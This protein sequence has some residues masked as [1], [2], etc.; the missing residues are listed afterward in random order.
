VQEHH[1]E[2]DKVFLPR[3]RAWKR[4]PGNHLLLGVGTRPTGRTVPGNNSRAVA[5]R[6]HGLKRFPALHLSWPP[7]RAPDPLL[8]Q[9]GGRDQDQ[10]QDHRESFEATWRWRL[11]LRLLGHKLDFRFP[12]PMLVL[13]VP[14]HWTVLELWDERAEMEVLLTSADSSRNRREPSWKVLGPR[15]P[16]R[17]PRLTSERRSSAY[18]RCLA[19]QDSEGGRRRS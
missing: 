7:C 6:P 16:E 2:T 4:K 18:W 17:R 19:T 8:R 10:D 5:I 15:S 14:L 12:E 1:Q 11:R 13:P 3:H 9:R